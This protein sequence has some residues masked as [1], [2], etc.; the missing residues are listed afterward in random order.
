MNYPHV[1][2]CIPYYRCQQY[3]RRAVE[4]LLAQTY[5]ELTVV[6]VNDGDTLTPPWA[7]LNHIDDPRLVR[8]DLPVNRGPYFANALVL[9]A[10]EAPYFLV[11]DADDWSEPERVALLLKKALREKSSFV[12]S[13]QN[14][15]NEND[16]IIGMRWAASDELNKSGFAFKHSLSAEFRN[17]AGHH[18]L[19]RSKDLLNLG[20]YYGGFKINYDVFLTNLVLMTGKISHVDRPLYNYFVR[21]ESLSRGRE[22][23]FRSAER[24]A[25]IR[26]LSEFYGKAYD[27]YCRFR[28]GALPSAAFL[29]ALREICAANIREEDR[30]ALR[31]EMTRLEKILEDQF[32]GYVYAR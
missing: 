6:V 29:A 1:M 21:R 18:G 15:R 9:H 14:E 22:F 19:F 7:P 8:F 25:V 11:Q 20:G 31:I 13:S 23:G 2:A 16:E 4:S 17:N 5:P 3:I 28:N 10:T 26:E 27:L 32:H 12:L 24:A 30:I